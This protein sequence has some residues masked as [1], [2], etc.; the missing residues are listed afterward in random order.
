VTPLAAL[1]RWL[2]AF[3]KEPLATARL[4]A[5]PTTGDDPPHATSDP[6]TFTVD[7]LDHPLVFTE[8]TG[9]VA[10]TIDLVED[11]A[12][13]KAALDRQLGATKFAG[14]DAHGVPFAAYPNFR[15]VLLLTRLDDTTT[16]HLEPH[17]KV[18][19]GI[20]PDVAGWL[21]ARL[22][23]TSR[24][25][26]Q[27]ASHRDMQRRDARASQKSGRIVNT[28]D[29]KTLAGQFRSLGASP[30]DRAA[31][32]S[33]AASTG[34]LVERDSPSGGIVFRLAKIPSLLFCGQGDRAFLNIVSSGDRELP[35]RT[36]DRYLDAIRK[37]L[38]TELGAATTEDRDARWSLW[39]L[40]EALVLVF[41][42][43]DLIDY[44]PQTIALC[45]LSWPRGRAVP[46]FAS[47]A[48]F[49]TT[50]KQGTPSAA[51]ADAFA[52][53]RPPIID[54]TRAQVAE[55]ARWFRAGELPTTDDLVLMGEQEGAVRYRPF[56][57]P[58]L[59][60]VSS[61]VLSIKLATQ[62]T[63]RGSA[64]D[65]AFAVL[66]DDVISTLGRPSQSGQDTA[67]GRAE[68]SLWLSDSVLVVLAQQPAGHGSGVVVNLLS[69]PW[70]SPAAPVVGP[71][72]S[73]WLSRLISQTS[74]PP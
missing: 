10:A 49:F 46:T 32:T 35:W 42:G 24:T 70:S 36:V 7:E 37:D 47:A 69:I 66:R 72:I 3:G 16:L 38:V 41:A 51:A 64:I 71:S 21:A 40:P 74:R 20:R 55:L 59:I 44:A 18:F 22:E 73:L 53:P 11:F 4:A 33:W 58:T 57:L 62:L 50:G 52:E 29:T 61:K 27:R 23:A 54:A 39:R 2:H 1:A 8:R 9:V 56:G 60:H 17:A 48:D 12:F 63:D 28:T 30:L 45:L 5:I 65:A 6:F 19:E 34:A 67:T 43:G 13:A 25:D 31:L 14:V 68:W 26:A 15:A